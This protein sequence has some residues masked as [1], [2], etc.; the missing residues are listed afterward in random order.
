MKSWQRICYKGFIVFGIFPYRNKWKLCFL[1][2]IIHLSDKVLITYKCTNLWV[3]QTHLI[4][5][6][7]ITKQRETRLCVGSIYQQ[8]LMLWKNRLIRLSLMCRR[9]NMTF[10]RLTVGSLIIFG[11][12]ASR[13]SCKCHFF[14]D[15]MHVSSS[16]EFSKKFF[17]CYSIEFYSFI[18]TRSNSSLYCQVISIFQFSHTVKVF[19]NIAIQH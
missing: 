18:F 16:K 1:F 17:L 4:W 19:Q 8:Y 13:V 14:L 3:H 2:L 11:I 12:P 5:S 9:G 7:H 15:S 10:P 6:S